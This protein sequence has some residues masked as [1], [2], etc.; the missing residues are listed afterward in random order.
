MAD[1]LLQ[2]VDLAQSVKRGDLP[3]VQNGYAW[4]LTPYYV[5][6]DYILPYD[7]PSSPVSRDK[8]LRYSTRAETMWSAAVKIAATKMQALAFN[9]SGG[10]GLRT[11]RAQELLLHA[12]GAGW[13]T[14][15]GKVMRDYLTTNNGVFFEIERYSRG[16]G[17]KI[18]ALHHLDSLRCTRTGDPEIPVIYM[19]LKGERHEL[20]YWQVVTLSSGLVDARAESYGQGECAADTAW[21]TIAKLAAIE[22]FVFEKVAGRRPLALHFVS[23]VTTI[24]IEDTIKGAQQGADAKGQVVYMGAAISGAISERPVA[25]VTIPLAELPDGFNPEQERNYGLLAYA[26]AIGIDLQD[27]QPLSKQGFGTGAQSEILSD[28]AAGKGLAAFRQDFIHAINELVLDDS[29]TFAFSENDIRD[30]KDKAEVSK[31]RAEMRSIMI[32][33]REI[34]NVQAL[35]MAVDSDDAPREFLPDDETAFEDLS[36]T[37]KP[38]DSQEQAGEIVEELPIEEPIVEE[39]VEEKA[40]STEIVYNGDTGQWLT[41]TTKQAGDAEKLVKREM[42]EAKSLYEETKGE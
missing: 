26:D 22:R 21:R 28:K 18:K 4:F 30:Q 3:K 11:R 20:K 37:E 41:I 12:D 7:L 17:A 5:P 14:F 33:S 24:Q 13:V 40:I 10:V 25:V 2:Y 31:I 19:G 27:L 23:G 38:V 36:D 6:G 9:V 39:E 32:A 1:E 29:T 15:S 16:R 42:K 8:W 34:N 35:Q